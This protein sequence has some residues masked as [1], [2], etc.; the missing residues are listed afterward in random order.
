MLPKE[1]FYSTMNQMH[2]TGES[3]MHIGLI[4]GTGMDLLASTGKWTEVSTPYGPAYTALTVFGGRDVA[5]VQ[6]HGQGLNVPPHLINYHANI[7]ALR[8][9]GVSRVLATAA[10]GSMRKD[11]PPGTFAVI[12]DFIDFTKHRDTTI[13]DRPA[14]EV[15]HVDFTHPYCPEVSSALETA[16]HDLGIGLGRRVVYVCVDGPR[17]ETPAEIRM[18]AQ[19]GGDVVGMTGVPEVV[20]ARE[21]GMCYGALAILTNY[22]AGITD[23]PLSHGDVR[24][25]VTK[26]RETVCGILERAVSQLDGNCGCCLSRMHPKQAASDGSSA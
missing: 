7:W 6:R 2:Q 16:A 5:M 18:F 4:A 21:F 20:L 25:S 24:T 26:C 10:V 22:A 3:D 14:A 12:G 13:F 9:M 17:Y 8:N 19:W 15:V 23:R 11:M 1:V